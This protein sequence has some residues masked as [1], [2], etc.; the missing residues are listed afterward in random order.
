[1]SENEQRQRGIIV[2]YHNVSELIRAMFSDDYSGH[3]EIG[4]L[5]L[6]NTIKEVS[7]HLE[8]SDQQYVFSAFVEFTKSFRKKIEDKDVVNW[9]KV[10]QFREVNTTGVNCGFILDDNGKQVMEVYMYADE[11]EER[12]EGADADVNELCLKMGG[13]N[14]E[15]LAKADAKEN[16]QI[17]EDKL[18]YFCAV[19]QD[20]LN[21]IY[22]KKFDDN[23]LQGKVPNVEF[24]IG[25]D[26][27]FYKSDEDVWDG[28]VIEQRQDKK[29]ASKEE[30][31]LSTGV[32]FADIGGN[33][34]AKEEA[35]RIVRELQSQDKAK[36]WAKKP[37]TGVLFYGPSGV[38]K[39]YL[40]QAMA[41]E[42]GMN[43]ISAT[44]ADINE[45]WVGSSER[46]MQKLFDDARRLAPCILFIDEIELFFGQR[47]MQNEYSRLVTSVLL[48]NISGVNPDSMKGVVLVACTNSKE[49]IDGP[50]IRSGRFQKIVHFE[51]PNLEERQEIF[52]I[53]VA[54]TEKRAER[55]VFAPGIDWQE[56]AKISD[57]KTGADIDDI[58][59]MACERGF[60]S[61]F[62]D[63]PKDLITMEDLREAI[64]KHLADR[65]TDEKV[66]GFN[67]KVS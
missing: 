51:M 63:T 30:K 36:R 10:R 18:R 17:V 62:T 40:V 65:K 28:R 24:K 23:A 48:Q 37:T 42:S 31:R 20:L 13:G 41:Q 21:G 1:M 43:F 57:G 6:N 58:I 50:L 3:Y 53:K 26:I 52:G 64:S 45:M 54:A 16:G 47:A 15:G 8:V 67:K 25:T 44:P 19:L 11:N 49:L 32:F 60:D 29:E 22:E 14:T 4:R 39:T 7:V 12:K 56:I 59:N 55:P 2:T 9:E 38:G 27:D 46:N 66:V 61:E 34:R 5:C 33:K 35:M